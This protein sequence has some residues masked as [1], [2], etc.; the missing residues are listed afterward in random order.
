MQDS[1]LMAGVSELLQ[2]GSSLLSNIDPQT[3]DDICETGRKSGIG[4][5]RQPAKDAAGKGSP[6]G[7]GTPKGGGMVP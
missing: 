1:E 7:K 3:A 2:E 5:L 4:Q 6:N